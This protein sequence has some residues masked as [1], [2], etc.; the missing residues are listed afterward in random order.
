V[1][2]QG[3]LS[4]RLVIGGCEVCGD[5]AGDGWTDECVRAE[6]CVTYQHCHGVRFYNKGKVVPVHAMK[7]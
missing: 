1:G 7:A 6:Q 2:W 3:G 4:C 5:W